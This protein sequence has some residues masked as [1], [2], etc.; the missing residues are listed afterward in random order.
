MPHSGHASPKLKGQAA[1]PH[2]HP[3]ISVKR[4]PIRVKRDLIRVKRDL[5]IV[6]RDLIG[7]ALASPRIRIN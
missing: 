5:I 3:L 6:K 4:D 1:L 2:L 7:V